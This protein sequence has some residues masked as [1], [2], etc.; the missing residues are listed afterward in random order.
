MPMRKLRA[1]PARLRG[2]IL[3]LVC[4]FTGSAWAAPGPAVDCAGLP[5]DQ[6]YA[7]FGNRLKASPDMTA[8]AARLVDAQLDRGECRTDADAGLARLQASLPNDPWTDYLVARTAAMDGKRDLAENN[9]RA[10]LS[11]QP[12]MASAMVLLATVLLDKEQRV[13]ARDLLA[14]A[15]AIE[16][17]DFRAA[18]Q[19]L[20]VDSLDA[21]KGEGVGKL[22]TVLRDRSLPP[23]ARETAQATLLYI[24]ALDLGQ[25]EAALR[26]SLSFQSRTPSAVKANNL[27]R[28]LAEESGKPEEARKVLRPALEA[29]GTP[30]DARALAEVLMAETW[31]LDAA[32]IDPAP[33]ARNAALVE[34]ARAQMHGDL[35]PLANRIR[36]YHDLA[37]LKP[38]VAE[39]RDPDERGPD[40]QTAL[41]R[42]S[43]LLDV[44]GVQRALDA[45]A[46]ADGECAGSTALAFLVRAGE[47]FF[48]RKKVMLQ[49]LMEAGADPDP[50]LYAGSSYTAIS[51]CEHGSP[52][53]AKS[54]LPILKEQAA[55]RAAKAQPAR[56]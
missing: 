56:P 19:T 34:K 29:D 32:A 25:K 8:P 52:G 12:R 6:A 27:A 24:T 33:S 42:A 5:T 50:K 14:Q 2:I 45:G 18:L 39:V 9:L 46:A 10:L 47:G 43:Q 4:A 37:A 11:D 1:E 55:L 51:F 7:F 44:D 22:F 35:I 38:F 13:P 28:L 40:G 48:D 53:C 31:L 23:D 17:K 15:M 30:P 36:R 16:P 3:C 49:A 41:C 21:P 26:E 20:R 54:L